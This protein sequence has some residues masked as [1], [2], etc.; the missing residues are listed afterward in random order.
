MWP[1][2]SGVEWLE[3]EEDFAAFK[4]VYDFNN[5]AKPGQAL[6]QAHHN[7][8]ELIDRHLIPELMTLVQENSENLNNNYREALRSAYEDMETANMSYL[9]YDR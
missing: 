4:G 8:P 5:V 1:V 9:I 6:T 2:S 7:L 3:P